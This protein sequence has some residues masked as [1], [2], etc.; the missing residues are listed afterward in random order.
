VPS[1]VPPQGS[2]LRPG[3]LAGVSV[4]LA[5]GGEGGDG[6]SEPLAASLTSLGAGLAALPA[7][8]PEGEDPAAAEGEVERRV[9]EA[10]AGLATAQLLVVDARSAAVED[11]AAL[12]R[13]MQSCWVLTRAVATAAFLPE[14]S[15]GRVVL[16]APAEGQHAAAA[17]AG[18]ENL[19]RTL[20]IEWARHGITI[21]AL[22]PGSTTSAEDLATIT[23]YLASRAGDY[24]SGCL[25]DL[26]GV[27][28]AG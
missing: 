15:R 16:I 13:C 10:L 14:G 26:R 1:A 18:L 27:I 3:L 22:A 7:S 6:E 17:A 21:V 4:L 11:A 19:A 8:L 28:A 2:L 25:F 5:T 20:S 23:A 24:F 9:G 12:T